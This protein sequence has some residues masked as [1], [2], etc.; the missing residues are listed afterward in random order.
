MRDFCMS[1]SNEGTEG[2]VQNCLCR[3]GGYLCDCRN[4]TGG[5]PA[6]QQSREDKTRV[7]LTVGQSIFVVIVVGKLSAGA[8]NLPEVLLAQ[9]FQQTNHSHLHKKRKLTQFCTRFLPLVSKV[10]CALHFVCCKLHAEHDTHSY[11]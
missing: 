6:T 2:R 5:L 7:R 9:K 4:V 11:Y 3:F 10:F 1:N 8:P